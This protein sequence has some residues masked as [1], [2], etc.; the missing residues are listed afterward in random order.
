LS[1]APLLFLC[2]SELLQADE[3]FS[4]EELAEA[5]LSHTVKVLRCLNA[6]E[7]RRLREAGSRLPLP[8][9][10]LKNIARSPES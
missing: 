4:N 8:R 2:L 1:R 10:S 5:V 6:A 9:A 7:K 3:L